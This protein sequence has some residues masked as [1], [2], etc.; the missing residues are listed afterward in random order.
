MSDD[1][2]ESL[3]EMGEVKP[4]A[5]GEVIRAAVITD[6]EVELRPGLRAT[7]EIVDD[8]C[9]GLTLVCDGA[10]NTYPDLDLDALRQIRSLLGEIIG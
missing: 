1:I 5:P 9:Y 7:I 3:D 2:R 6:P 4:V 8:N 10:I